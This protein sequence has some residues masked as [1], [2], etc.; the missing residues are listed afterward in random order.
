[1]RNVLTAAFVAGSAAGLTWAGPEIQGKLPGSGVR[2]PASGSGSIDNPLTENF[3]SY[4]VGQGIVGQNGWQLWNAT[5]FDGIITSSTAAAGTR[6]FEA[7]ASTDV[8]QVMDVTSGQWEVKVMT[9]VPTGM[10]LEGF[11]IMLN[12]FSAPYVSGGNW[13]LQI[14]FNPT[15]QQVICNDWQYTNVNPSIPLIFDQ[16][17]ELRATIDLDVQPNG[18]L[19][20]WYGG[21]QFVFDHPWYPHVS[22]PS[23]TAAVRIQCINLYSQAA[24]FKWDEL[25]FQPLTTGP[26][27][28]PNCDNSTQVPFLNVADF[29]CF[30]GK[31][32]AADPYA[33][34][35]GSTTP[36]VH[37]VADFSCFLSKFAAGCSAP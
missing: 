8:V 11:F 19:N 36:P 29:S 37:N 10:P 31:F 6:S 20:V 7:V 22:V 17:V 12:T 2:L 33:N 32:A 1:M 5:V 9:Y 28:Y 14:R 24:G 27:C 30:L 3:E 35:D 16:W 21:T 4:T 25:S 26:T 34:C 13:S 15:T 23:P 18:L